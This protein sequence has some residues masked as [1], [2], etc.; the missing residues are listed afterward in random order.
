M[1][2]TPATALNVSGSGFDDTA[3]GYN[4]TPAIKAGLP[5]RVWTL[6]DLANLPE[7][8]RNSKAV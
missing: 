4:Y 3:L 2:A 5:D 7:V 6:H 1:L 8:L